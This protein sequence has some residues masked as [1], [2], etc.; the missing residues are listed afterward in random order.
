MATEMQMLKGMCE[1]NK[2]NN[3]SG[4]QGRASDKKYET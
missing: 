4:N 1:I 2:I 3:N